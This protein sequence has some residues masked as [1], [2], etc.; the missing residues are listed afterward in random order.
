MYFTLIAFSPCSP[1]R[2]NPVDRQILTAK[3]FM[4]S[5]CGLRAADPLMT[6]AV[7]GGA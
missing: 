3:V 1:F 4:N 6:Y 5:H 2:E 7:I